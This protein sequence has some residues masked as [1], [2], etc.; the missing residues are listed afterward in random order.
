MVYMVAHNKFFEKRIKALIFSDINTDSMK[1]SGMKHEPVL[2]VDA[3]ETYLI[4]FLTHMNKARG[5]YMSDV[6]IHDT[7]SNSAPNGNVNETILAALLS[8]TNGLTKKKL[9]SLKL[10]GIDLMEG[11]QDDEIPPKMEIILNSLVGGKTSSKAKELTLRL[12]DCKLDNH[13]DFI[14]TDADIKLGSLTISEC[15]VSDKGLVSLMKLAKNIP[16]LKFVSL[17]NNKIG[18]DGV[19]EIQ[20]IEENFDRDVSLFLHS[21]RDAVSGPIDRKKIKEISKNMKHLTITV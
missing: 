20:K 9:E 16:S 17:P 7:V 8:P 19:K 2:S 4:D 21:N 11:A 10:N 15:G 5:F 1:T 13:F 12:S 18:I 3:Y 14:K 6:E